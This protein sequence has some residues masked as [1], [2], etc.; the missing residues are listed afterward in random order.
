MFCHW[1]WI[2][3]GLLEFYVNRKYGTYGKQKMEELYVYQM[4]QNT[5]PS[6]KFF[7]IIHIVLEGTTLA[8][9][10]NF[11]MLQSLSLSLMILT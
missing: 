11:K 6:P 3:L 9:L 8:S 7:L 5:V 4:L 10:S 2:I 1:I